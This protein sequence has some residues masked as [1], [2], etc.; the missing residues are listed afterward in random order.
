LAGITQYLVGFLYF[1]EVS[2]GSLAAGIFIG[3]IPLRQ[4]S[5]R[6]FYF[7]HRG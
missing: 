6:L 7:L 4:F 5:E 3:M 1:P 2:A